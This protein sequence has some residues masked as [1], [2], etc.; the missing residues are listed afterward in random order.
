[1]NRFEASWQRAWH[2][3]SAQGTGLP[4]RDEL[5]ARY[6]EPHRR[7]HTQQHLAECLAHFERAASWV[8]HDGEVEI[9]L[10]FHDAIYEL[11]S[12]RNEADSAAWAERALRQA[13]VNEP[14]V[15]RVK[16]L[17]MATRHDALPVAPDEQLLVDIDLAILG[18]P[19]QRFMAYEAQVRQEYAWVPAEA[20]R[21]GRSAV[22][23]QFLERA[24]VYSTAPFRERLEAQAHG[25]MRASLAR[26]AA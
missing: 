11:Q 4:L 8:E 2:A 10:W 20:Y 25:N 9:A 1:M 21:Q 16:A 12:K 26:L 22:L 23:R 5:L 24:T 6:A 13:G 17:V 15:Q 7:Y 14:A 3:L 19:E 18:A